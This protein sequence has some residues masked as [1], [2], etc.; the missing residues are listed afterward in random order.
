MTVVWRSRWHDATRFFVAAAIGLLPG[1]TAWVLV[2]T[3]IQRPLDSFVSNRW[4]DSV[5]YWHQIKSFSQ[6]GFQCGHYSWNEIG[7]PIDALHYDVHGP[8]FPMLYGGFASVFGWKPYSAFYYNSVVVAL[9]V[10][11]FGALTAATLRQM[12]LLSAMLCC[13]WTVPLYLISPN[14]EPVHMAAALVFAGMFGRR[15]LV[16]RDVSRTERCLSW[17]F[18]TGMCLM[19]MSWCILAVPLLLLDDR[20][21]S[22]TAPLRALA[23]GGIYAAGV[24][25]LFRLIAAPG[26]NVTVSLLSSL[27]T[28][29]GAGLRLVV[30]RLAPNVHATFTGPRYGTLQ[31]WLCIGLLVVVLAI[32]VNAWLRD[33]SAGAPVESRQALAE[34]AFHWY[35][36]GGI[37][38]LSWLFYIADG[39]ERI[40]LSHLLLSLALLLVARR[41]WVLVGAIVVMLVGAPRGFRDFTNDHWDDFR[42][43]TTMV[44]DSAAAL[45]RLTP[46]E[47]SAPSPWCNTIMIHLNKYDWHVIAIPPGMGVSWAFKLDEPRQPIQS[48]YVLG[49]DEELEPLLAHPSARLLLL[50]RLPDGLG[51]YLNQRSACE[52][53]F[54]RRKSRQ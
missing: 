5:G 30:S 53:V 21:G 19:R 6:V 8:L 27:A 47:E 22:G 45:A 46:Y 31:A 13:S 36:L 37:L 34:M 24:M 3:L 41:E 42:V 44:G 49:S 11:I 20:R 51:V 1:A 16:S 12:A 29:P 48:R 23:L 26:G 32:A 25:T 4:N 40:H 15:L 7:A 28:S 33:R 2:R 38:L 18:L 9:G 10:L 39:F 52:S 43:D 17:A 14:E 54:H 35:Q 50:D